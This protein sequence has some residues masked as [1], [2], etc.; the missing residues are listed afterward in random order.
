MML[1]ELARQKLDNPNAKIDWNLVP[2]GDWQAYLPKYLV[3]AILKT[4]Y[5]DWQA[6]ASDFSYTLDCNYIAFARLHYA[7]ERAYKENYII[8]EQADFFMQKYFYEQIKQI[9][10]QNNTNYQK[11]A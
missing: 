5:S 4:R 9:S 2:W 10:K 7:I 8:K 3:K 6:V 11:I 1:N